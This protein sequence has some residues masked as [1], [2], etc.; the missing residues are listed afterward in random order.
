ML[1]PR[2]PV[3]GLAADLAELAPQSG[4]SAARSLPAGAALH[5]RSRTQVAC[6]ACAAA[7]SPALI[8]VHGTNLTRS[9]VRYRPPPELDPEPLRRAPVATTL[10]PDCDLIA[11]ILNPNRSFS[12]TPASKLKSQANSYWVFNKFDPTI[13]GDG[14]LHAIGAKNRAK[15]QVDRRG[16]W[17][18]QF[19][20][21]SAHEGSSVA[22]D[23]AE[24]LHGLARSLLDPYRPEL[25]Y[26]RGP[27]PKWHAK[28]DRAPAT[29]SRHR[30][31]AIPALVRVRVKGCIGRQLQ[32]VTNRPVA[33]RAAPGRPRGCACPL[34]LVRLPRVL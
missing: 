7:G 28:H 3:L 5:A 29:V 25:H 18:R 13:A 8:L 6:Q 10:A 33:G 31:D 32:R 21:A 23:L 4:P 14:A 11:S 15:T 26:M 2:R 16:S 19:E 9:P 30:T 34:R 20:A 27:G 17:E 24:F 1:A 22:A 12:A